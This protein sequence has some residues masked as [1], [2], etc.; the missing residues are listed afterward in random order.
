MLYWKQITFQN[1]NELSDDPVCNRGGDWGCER[2]YNSDNF[3][4]W[5]T[6]IE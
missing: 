6:M 2:D 4:D 1:K 3:I 5:L